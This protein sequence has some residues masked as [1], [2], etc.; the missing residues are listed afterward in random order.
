MPKKYP[1]WFTTLLNT[2]SA[3]VSDR[4]SDIQDIPPFGP[5]RH[6]K[7]GHYSVLFLSVNS[8]NDREG[9]AEVIYVSLT[10]G[11]VHNCSLRQWQE[12]VQWP[13]GVRRARYVPLRSSLFFE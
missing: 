12:A 10:T 13:D 9:E 1:T 4:Y 5:Y 7:G 3:N 2:V 11:A 8:N 6:Y